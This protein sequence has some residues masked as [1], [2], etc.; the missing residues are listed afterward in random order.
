MSAPTTVTWAEALTDAL[1]VPAAS[2]ADALRRVEAALTDEND[3]SVFHV[4]VTGGA[5][6][7]RVPLS[8]DQLRAA[9]TAAS[10]TA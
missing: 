5:D 1:C 6:P 8:P 7:V 10:V 9:L 4:T 3:C 2:P